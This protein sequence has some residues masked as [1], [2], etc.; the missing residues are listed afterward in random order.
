MKRLIILLLFFIIA[1]SSSSSGNSPT[2]TNPNKP[3][4]NSLAFSPSTVTAGSTL[5]IYIEFTFTDINGDLD[6]A[7]LSW[8]YE[9]T[10][11]SLMLG[12][13]FAGSTS[14]TGYGSFIGTISSTKGTIS[15]PVW[16][17]DKAGN[18]SDKLTVY[19]TQV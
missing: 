13:S 17:T 9:G 4:L 15:V 16:L 10:T 2:A 7:S 14:G 6:G 8:T 12:S 18:S 19:I 1:C 5:T 3:V 11:S